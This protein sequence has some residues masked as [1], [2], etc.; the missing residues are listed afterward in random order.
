MKF[1]LNIGKKSLFL[2][3][4]LFICVV[5]A[6]CSD[7]TAN[8]ETEKQETEENEDNQSAEAFPVT[9]SVDD[10]EVTVEEKPQNITAPQRLLWI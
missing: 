8:S 1:R 5:M 6:A 9:V 3:I 10:T 2:V 7:S 4:M